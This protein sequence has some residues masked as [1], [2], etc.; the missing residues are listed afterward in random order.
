[1]RTVIDQGNG[2]K[3][4]V[5]LNGDGSLT[6]GTMQDCESILERSK[7]LHNEGMHGSKDMR[8]AASIPVVVIEKWCNDNGI[9][10]ADLGRSPDLK[11][12]MLSD[13]ALSS[14]RVWKGRI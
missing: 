2:V 13:P 3:T 14:F 11:R 5:Q 9:A 6:T 8:L 12:R 4:L 1:M 10:Y 7:A